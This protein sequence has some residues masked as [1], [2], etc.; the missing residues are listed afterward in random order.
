MRQ[1]FAFLETSSPLRK[2]QRY[3]YGHVRQA[4]APRPA[5]SRNIRTRIGKGGATLARQQQSLTRREFM[6]LGAGA[7]TIVVA[8]A[9][10]WR[11]VAMLSSDAPNPSTERIAEGEGRGASPNAGAEGAQANETGAGQN[12][13]ANEP[14]AAQPDDPSNAPRTLDELPWNLQL[15]NGSH[16]LSADFAPSELAAIPGGK[17]TIDSRV[18]EALMAMLDA[19]D[20]AGVPPAICSAYRTYNYQQQLFEKRV[21]RCRKE[22]GLKGEEAEREAAFWV[23]RP[24]ASEHQAGLA[25]DL[26]DKN[27]TELDENQES[28][29]TQK[30]LM[31]YCAEYGFILRYPT[32]KSPITGIGYEPWH[33]RYVGTEFASS[34]TESGLCFEEWLERYLTGN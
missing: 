18:Y 8:G 32:A 22:K 24:G 9:T 29:P 20:S 5:A 27:Y 21:E 16:P 31:A 19:A 6:A 14:G 25:I 12:A 15:I 3:H 33:Y 17:H 26:I 13:T 11:S 4:D 10:A 34:I 7:A 1:V 28:T 2:G 23:A 30:W